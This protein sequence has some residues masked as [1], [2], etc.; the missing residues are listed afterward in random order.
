MSSSDPSYQQL[1]LDAISTCFIPSSSGSM[2]MCSSEAPFF[3]PSIV[4]PHDA[5]F[6]SGSGSGSGV[7]AD[8]AAHY[9]YMANDA[10]ETD[11][12]AY[13]GA[14]SCSTVHSMSMFPAFAAGPLGF[15]QYGGP[16]DVTIAQ[17]P[18]RMSK[19]ITG[20]PHCNSWLYDGPS[21]V[22]IHEPYYLAPFSGAGSFPAASGLSLRLGAALSSSVTMASLPEQSSDVSCSGLTH[23]NSEGFGYQQQPETTVK[24]HAESD[25]GMPMPFQLPPYPEMYST[26]PHLSQVLPRS[27]Y[28]HVAQELLNGFAAC[29]LNDVADH[30]ISD[31][32]PGNGGI[33][34]EASSNKLMLP[35]IEQRQDDVR[36]DLLRLLQLVSEQ[37]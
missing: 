2:M 12:D 6:L 24:A 9:N 23:A 11:E 32:G 28:A 35:S 30:N 3:H 37:S 34:S 1:G 7:G 13:A 36:G 27:R 19:L 14:E 20:E 18:S 33:G 17:P 15:F 26:P 29:L 4:V 25:D 10:M 21:A 5:S 8:V 22:S 16:A 31:F